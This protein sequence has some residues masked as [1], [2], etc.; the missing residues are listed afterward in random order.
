MAIVA[1]RIQVIID[2][3]EKA[4]AGIIEDA[5]AQERRYLEESRRRA[6]AMAAQRAQAI[7]KLADSLIS[8]RA[9]RL[10]GQQE[11]RLQAVETAPA[12]PLPVA[13]DSAPQPSG[14]PAAGLHAPIPASANF[15]ATQM[16]ASG[17]SRA[18]IEARLCEENGIDDA[19]SMLDAILGEEA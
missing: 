2:A 14:E 17:G 5:E 18:E 1:E 8:Q 6:D 16:A 10:P 15:L 12:E 11:P 9:T 13:A 3:A 19:D 4:A 7:S